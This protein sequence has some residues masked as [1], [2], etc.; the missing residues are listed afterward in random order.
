MNKTTKI[1]AIITLLLQSYMSVG[2]SP[3]DS[4]YDNSYVHTIHINF[5]EAFAFAQWKGMRLPT[6]HEWEVASDQ[7]NYGQLWE[8]T[9][10]AYLPYPNYAKADGALGEYN[11]KFMV[12]QMVL[13]GASVATAPNFRQCLGWRKY[14]ASLE[15]LL[16][17]FGP[18][19]QYC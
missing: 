1:L 18:T 6:E 14:P 17:H 4:L 12:N 10:S 13:R 2:Q 7:L 11:G 5:Y 3:G 8:W 15:R 9:N 16:P 19:V